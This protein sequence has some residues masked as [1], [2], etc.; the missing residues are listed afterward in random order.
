M[1]PVTNLWMTTRANF[2]PVD[3]S[4]SRGYRRRGLS[5]LSPLQ[6][7]PGVLVPI[8]FCLDRPHDEL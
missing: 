6:G 4:T 2:P 3:S 7:D 8:A 1:L 5:G